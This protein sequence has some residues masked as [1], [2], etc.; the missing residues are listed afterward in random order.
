MPRLYTV[1]VK[2]TS[3]PGFI[4]PTCPADSF[5]TNAGSNTNHHIFGVVIVF[6]RRR[7]AIAGIAATITSDGVVR[8]RVH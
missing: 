1:M 5:F 6:I 8:N 7:V 2:F 3:S 4:M